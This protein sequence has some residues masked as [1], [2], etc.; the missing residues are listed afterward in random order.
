MGLTSSCVGIACQPVALDFGMSDTRRLLGGDLGL[1]RVFPFGSYVR[2]RHRVRGDAWGQ[3]EPPGRGAGWLLHGCR[4][5]GRAVRVLALFHLSLPS[6]AGVA[7]RPPAS[8]ICIF[9]TPG[10]AA[11]ACFRHLPAGSQG[12]DSALKGPPRSSAAEFQNRPSER[13]GRTALSATWHHLYHG[14]KTVTKATESLKKGHSLLT[15]T[16]GGARF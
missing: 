9:G 7:H 11:P 5:G 1:G 15:L 6:P 8:S 12:F 2:G 4:R 13:I 3:R 16:E 14:G 10:G